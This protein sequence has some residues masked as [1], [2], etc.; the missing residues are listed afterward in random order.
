MDDYI[1]MSCTLTPDLNS[2]V[3]AHSAWQALDRLTSAVRDPHQ[4]ARRGCEAN[5]NSDGCVICARCNVT[6][7]CTKKCLTRCAFCRCGISKH[8]GTD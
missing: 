2:P 4:C 3:W 7:Y 8:G 6:T 5:T 1:A